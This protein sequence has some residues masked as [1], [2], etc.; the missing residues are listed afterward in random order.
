MYISLSLYLSLKFVFIVLFVNHD[1][2]DPERYLN[3]TRT[4]PE[5][6]PNITLRM[7]EDATHASTLT[8]VSV[9]L[10]PFWS[11]DPEVWFTQVETQFTTR[12]ITPQNTRFD[13]VISS[14][15]PEIALEVRD[16]L[17]KPPED[18]LLK[19][20]EDHPYDTLKAQLIKHTAASEQRNSSS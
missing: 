10:P 9:K 6:Y 3:A 15:S 13:N 20:P 5:R 8:A 14:L 16:L 11:A 19:P 2:G 4:L 17:L 18:L 12:G 1:I 7:T